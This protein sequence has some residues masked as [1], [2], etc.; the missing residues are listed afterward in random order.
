MGQSV[1]GDPTMIHADF[2]ER[3]RMPRRI[4]EPG[5]VLSKVRL[6]GGREWTVVDISSGGALLDGDN[7]LLPGTH[8]DVHVTTRDGRVLVRARV[9]RASVV[10]LRADVVGYHAALAFE[11][12]V[13]T[14]TRGYA[15]PAVTTPIV[16]GSTVYPVDSGE[17]QHE[18]AG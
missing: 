13:D 11:A 9:V 10:R 7:R 14:L 8:V 17:Q 2:V 12:S 15:V 1:V 3:R 16:V 6:R 18:I 5:E 4:P